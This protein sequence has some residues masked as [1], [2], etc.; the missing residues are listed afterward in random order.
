MNRYARADRAL[1]Q[2]LIAHLELRRLFRPQPSVPAPARWSP[3][4]WLWTLAILYAASM[5]FVLQFVL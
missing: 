3:D 2:L 5:I 1:L 4:R